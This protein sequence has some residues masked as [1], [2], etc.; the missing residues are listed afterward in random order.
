MH[1]HKTY[2]RHE[3]ITQ[4][5]IYDRLVA[6]ETKVD[7]IETNTQ[8]VVSAFSAAKGAFIVLD[9]LSK[10]AKPILWIVGLATSISFIWSEW[11]RR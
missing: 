3:E 2:P 8:D 4:K 11:S 5:E 7:R 10:A 6:V 9:W 1:T